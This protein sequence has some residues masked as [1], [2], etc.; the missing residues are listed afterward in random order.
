MG[1][2]AGADGFLQSV[3]DVVGSL[4]DLDVTYSI[5]VSGREAKIVAFPEGLVTRIL[6]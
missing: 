5:R 4:A 3:G 6:L 2:K 1:T